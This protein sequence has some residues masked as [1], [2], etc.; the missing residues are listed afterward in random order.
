MNW[1]VYDGGRDEQQGHLT[2]QGVM[3][4]FG[5]TFEILGLGDFGRTIEQSKLFERE[6]ETG[7]EPSIEP[8]I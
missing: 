1:Q 7:I 2:Q 4:R 3:P 8:S 6:I 5:S